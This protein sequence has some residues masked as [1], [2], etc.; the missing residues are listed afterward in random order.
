M[1]RYISALKLLVIVAVALGSAYARAGGSSG[2]GALEVA[3]PGTRVPPLPPKSSIT[4]AVLA[5][6][7]VTGWLAWPQTSVG[8]AVIG[9]RVVLGPPP[10]RVDSGPRRLR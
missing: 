9:A 4:G 7:T 2:D 8:V 10:Q 6:M 5:R 1:R 3:A